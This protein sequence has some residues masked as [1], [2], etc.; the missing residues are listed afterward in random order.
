M[1]TGARV[2]T[3]DVVFAHTHH[4]LLTHL[5]RRYGKDFCDPGV[6]FAILLDALL[7]G[8]WMAKNLWGDLEQFCQVFS[9]GY[10]LRQCFQS[11]TSPSRSSVH[12]FAH[13]ADLKSILPARLSDLSVFASAGQVASR[14]FS[15]PLILTISL[16]ASNNHSPNHA[17][18]LSSPLA[19]MLILS[20]CERCR[21]EIV[22]SR[23][24]V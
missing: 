13:L 22:S 1:G 14:V 15:I 23:V 19:Y 24:L 10:I 2:L 4:T 20:Y 8:P 18:M 21:L 16:C 6:I 3:I 7:L 11:V 12:A 17:K 9:E 5:A